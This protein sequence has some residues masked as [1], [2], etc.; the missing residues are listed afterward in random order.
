MVNDRLSRETA[1][2]AQAQGGTWKGQVVLEKCKHIILS[3]VIY[4]GLCYISFL[5]IIKFLLDFTFKKIYDFLYVIFN[6]LNMEV[7]LLLVAYAIYNG[8]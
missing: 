1:P 2:C 3:T 5:Y 6:S 8:A 4:T 7:L